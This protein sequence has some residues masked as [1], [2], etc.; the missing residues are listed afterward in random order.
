VNEAPTCGD[1]SKSEEKVP[2]RS[3]PLPR[4]RRA[5]GA[6]GHRFGANLLCDYCGVAY[7]DYHRSPNV[8]AKSRAA[9]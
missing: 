9:T 7:R 2:E 5:Q 1:E 8:C 3:T 4:E 6:S